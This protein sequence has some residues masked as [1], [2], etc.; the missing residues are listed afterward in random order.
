M[1]DRKYLPS[2]RFLV[3]LALAI[4]IIL[5]A[6]AFNYRGSKTGNPDNLVADINATTSI[7]SLNNID[8][9]QDGLPDWQEVLYGTDP[10][11][12]DTDGDGT[13][14]GEE[15]KLNRDPLKANTAPKGQ[16]PNDKISPDLI[17]NEQ[18]ISEEYQKLNPIEKMARNLMSNIIAS[19]PA[20]GQIDLATMDSLV[21]KSI[22]DLPQKQYVGIT[23][24]SDLNLISV[25]PKTLSN[26]LL[27]YAK[28]YYAETEIFRKIMGQDLVIINNDISVSKTVEKEKVALITSKYQAIINNLIKTPLP[29]TPESSGAIYHLIII[30]GLE[31]LVQIDNDIIKFSNDTSV[32]FSDLAEYNKTMN[33]ILLSLGTIDGILKINRQ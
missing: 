33:D 28:S 12:A 2:K 30:N 27:T 1:I 21:Q 17:A 11:K 10:H 22:D 15:I 5:I 31:K 25:D 18:K 23:K 16:E 32:L 26:T 13:P 14:D 20:S 3:A 6:V 9:D 29:A 24:M 7:D 19:Q 4:M 8:S